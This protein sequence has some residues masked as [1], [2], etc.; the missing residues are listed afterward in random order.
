[1]MEQTIL[2]EEKGMDVTCSTQGKRGENWE[3]IIE[4]RRELLCSDQGS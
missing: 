3:K 4:G 1:M 2:G